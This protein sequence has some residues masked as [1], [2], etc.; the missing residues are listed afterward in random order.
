MKIAESFLDEL[1]TKN[2]LATFAIHEKLKLLFVKYN[3]ALPSN[4]AVERPFLTGK[5]ALRPKRAGL[6]DEHF[7]MLVFLKGN[8]NKYCVA[9]LSD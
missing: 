1:P 7:N 9:I 2:I 8:F 4:A 5:D 6:S 3:T